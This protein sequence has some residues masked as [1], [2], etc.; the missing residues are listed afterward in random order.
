MY[1]SLHWLQDSCH[2]NTGGLQETP[3]MLQLNFQSQAEF[4]AARRGCKACACPTSVAVQGDTVPPRPA[5]LSFWAGSPGP[6][7]EVLIVKEMSA[8]IDIFP[9]IKHDLE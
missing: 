8:E 2:N 1:S 7:R 9:G 3:R 4:S 6:G 5:G